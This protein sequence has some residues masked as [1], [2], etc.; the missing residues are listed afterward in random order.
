MGAE[1]VHQAY[2]HDSKGCIQAQLEYYY[3][4]I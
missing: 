4:N 2:G 3:E 1:S